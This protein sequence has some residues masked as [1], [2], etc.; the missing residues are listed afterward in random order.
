MAYVSHSHA[1]FSVVAFISVMIAA[2]RQRRALAGLEAHR[3]ADIGISEA[4]AEAES[5]RPVWDVPHHW[6]EIR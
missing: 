2:R 6:Q 4:Q 3:L 5:R 1:R